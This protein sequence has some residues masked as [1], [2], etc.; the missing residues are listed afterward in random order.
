MNQSIINCQDN[1]YELEKYLKN[2]KN[3]FIVCSKSIKKLSI[4]NF[5]NKMPNLKITYFDNFTPNPS[6]DSVVLGVKVFQES[7]AQIIIAI[8][9]GSAIDVAKCIKLYGNM[10]EYKDIYNDTP[11]IAIPTTAGTGSEATSFAVI[12][13]NGEKVSIEDK[14]ILPSVVVFDPSVLETLPLYQRKTTMLDALSHSI[15]S[16]WSVNATIESKKYSQEALKIILSNMES[17]LENTQDG[18]NNMLKA[19][20]FAGKAINIAKTTAGH[21]LC[22]KLTSLYGIAH[23]HATALVNAQLYPYMINNL[24]KIPT[25]KERENLD[26]ILNEIASILGYKSPKESQN[27][28]IELL[29]NLDLYNVEI[30]NKDIDLLVKSVNIERL[31]NNPI[32]LEKIDIE[33]LYLKIIDEVEKRK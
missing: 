12:Y 23:G 14:R 2:Y 26:I 24:N 4:Y 18:N 32:K 10:D 6:Y 3:I 22:Y 11:L 16:Y 27:Y 28:F 17:Y 33:K 25:S 9:G 21:A 15:E 5:I 8:G 7:N 13:V 29:E 31:K 1:Y 30:N 19:A 20:N